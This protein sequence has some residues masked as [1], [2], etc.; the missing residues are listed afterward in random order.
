M[1]SVCS[2]YKYTIHVQV[3]QDPQNCNRNISLSCKVRAQHNHTILVTWYRIKVDNSE[4]V[5]G[6]DFPNLMDDEEYT[7]VAT[8]PIDDAMYKYRCQ[9]EFNTQTGPSNY[10]QLPPNNIHGLNFGT[11]GP[12]YM[13]CTNRRN[14]MVSKYISIIIHNEIFIQ[15][16]LQY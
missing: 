14:A 8:W 3:I 12:L 6:F 9:I 16:F 4:E 10:C 11:C 7:V 2:S 5:Q 13:C 15:S 1:D